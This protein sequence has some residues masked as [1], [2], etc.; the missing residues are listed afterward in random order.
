MPI[1]GV[2]NCVSDAETPFK[3]LFNA[4]FDNY[5]AY[6]LAY[7]RLASLE[8]P[9]G[10]CHPSSESRLHVD[11]LAAAFGASFAFA[12]AS[13]AAFA[14]AASSAFFFSFASAA[15]CSASFLST[16]ALTSAFFATAG[17]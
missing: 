10:C 8:R 3:T 9:A 2:F 17:G 5:A 14:A 1:R 15:F 4:V 11:H 7:R 13:S 16:A 6:R 12:A